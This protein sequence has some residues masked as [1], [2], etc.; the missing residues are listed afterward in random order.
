MEAVA[1]KSRLRKLTFGLLSLVVL[2]G[3]YWSYTSGRPD[4][5]LLGLGLLA[6]NLVVSVR[7]GLWSP[8]ISAPHT[9]PNQDKWLLY[10][11]ALFGISC[12]VGAVLVKFWA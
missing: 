10:A 2:G 12:F 6:F 3:S 7:N 9:S 8:V 5:A 1:K 11:I 4:T